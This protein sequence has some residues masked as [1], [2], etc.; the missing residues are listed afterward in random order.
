[1][2]PPF[3]QDF[4]AVAVAPYQTTPLGY[5]QLSISSLTTLTAALAAATPTYVLTGV[6]R[7]M[8]MSIEGNGIRW[9]DDGQTPTATYG[10]PLNAGQAFDF[11]GNFSAM[12]LVSQNGTATVNVSFGR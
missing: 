11:T 12:E 2:A 8:L 7:Y 10:Q 6:E 1:M 9:L 5:R 4:P 3:A